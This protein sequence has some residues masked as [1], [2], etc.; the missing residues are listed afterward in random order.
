M[1]TIEKPPLKYVGGK[2]RLYDRIK[3]YF[4]QSNKKSI[5]EPFAGSAAIFFM[6]MR[7]GLITN[8]SQLNDLS[9]PL[10]DFYKSLVGFLPDLNANL[11]PFEDN[12][13]SRFFY[14]VRDFDRFNLTSE[15]RLAARY[16]YINKTG[17]NGLYRVNGSGYC[18]TPWGKK[19]SF[20]A[21]Q[22]NLEWASNA[23]QSVT[24]QS[25]DFDEV[26]IDPNHFYFFDPPYYDTFDSYTATTP[27]KVFYQRL[28]AFICKLD[29]AGAK[30]LLTNSNNSFI[31]ELFNDYYQEEVDIT[32]SVSGLKKGRVPTKEL[33][34]SN[35]EM[36]NE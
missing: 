14:H 36:F 24:L 4:I 29:L 3:P 2:G 17:F 25:G 8:N 28:K 34:I 6:L 22:A 26:E 35:I 19:K 12:H 16:Y 32:Y 10:I 7:D 5:S 33:F 27:D 31:R 13:S 23:L 30:F 15:K 1:R 21:N 18:N 20:A 9:K 11:K